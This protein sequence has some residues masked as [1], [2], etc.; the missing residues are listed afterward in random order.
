MPRYFSAIRVPLLAFLLSATYLQRDER[1]EGVGKPL[2]E[3]I[4]GEHVTLTAVEVPDSRI[5]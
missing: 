3:F 1:S 2:F 5:Q 4:E